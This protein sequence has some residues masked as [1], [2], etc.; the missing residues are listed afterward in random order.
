[1]RKKM[2]DYQNGLSKEDLKRVQLF[3]FNPFSAGGFHA[4]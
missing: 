3:E 4:Q 1:M 2:F